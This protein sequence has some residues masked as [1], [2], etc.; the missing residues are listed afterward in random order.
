MAE[1]NDRVNAELDNIKQVL[2]KFP[3]DCSGSNL[4]ALEIAGIATLIHNFYNGTENIIKQIVRHYGLT[5]PVGPSWH[6]D[7]LQLTVE[8]KIISESTANGLK[9]YLAFRNFFVYGYAFELEFAKLKPLVEGIEGIFKSFEQ[10][11]AACL[12]GINSA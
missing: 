7:L 3:Q 5:L 8:S 11:I 6:R 10:D 9:R 2:A 4:S 12:V 1:I